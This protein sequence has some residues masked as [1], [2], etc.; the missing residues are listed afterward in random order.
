M[1]RSPGRVPLQSHRLQPPA[2][3]QRVQREEPPL[4]P[5]RPVRVLEVPRA[6][7]RSQ[8]A[9]FR[10]GP[11]LV[12]GERLP[13]V[14]DREALVKVLSCSGS[15]STSG[16]IKGVDWVTANAQEPAVAN[17]SLGGGA[18]KALKRKSMK[19]THPAM[20]APSSVRREAARQPAS[21]PRSQKPVG[22]QCH[23]TPL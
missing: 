8:L 3:A 22:V 11:D 9:G 2:L 5:A 21:W 13:G 1:S 23:C 7:H 12:A 16:V 6:R 20:L 14:F 17:M 10:F 15:G 18:S 19:L 4:R